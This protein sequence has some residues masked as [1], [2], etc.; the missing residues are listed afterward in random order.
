MAKK[1]KQSSFWSTSANG[2]TQTGGSWGVP[3]KAQ[4]KANRQKKSSGCLRI[5]APVVAALAALIVLVACNNDPQVMFTSCD[6]AREAGA[7]LPLT[8]DSPGWNPK[9]D[10]DHDGRAC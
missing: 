2:K 4:Q 9:L 1:R 10:R 6:Q 5:A 3:S 7:P 8:P